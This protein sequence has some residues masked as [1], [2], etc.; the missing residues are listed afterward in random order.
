ML[1]ISDGLIQKMRTERKRNN[2]GCRPTF[3]SIVSAKLHT[4]TRTNTPSITEFY[5]RI[6]NNDKASAE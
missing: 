2:V 4:N 1:E 6:H 3:S 5:Y